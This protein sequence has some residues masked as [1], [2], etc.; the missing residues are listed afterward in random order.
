MNAEDVYI[1]AAAA[2]RIRAFS[3]EWR[4]MRIFGLW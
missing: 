4:E 2:R 1:A 3:P